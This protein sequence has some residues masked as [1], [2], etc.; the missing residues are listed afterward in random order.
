MVAVGSIIHSLVSMDSIAVV[1]VV[2]AVAHLHCVC[3]AFP[4]TALAFMVGQGWMR[5][6]GSHV[7]TG[8]AQVLFGVSVECEV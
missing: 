3:V 2:A 1:A 6:Y 4:L 8:C 5:E 7:C